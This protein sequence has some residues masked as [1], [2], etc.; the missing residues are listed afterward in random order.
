MLLPFDAAAQFIAD[1]VEEDLPLK[2]WEAGIRQEIGRE[3][4]RGR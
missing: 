3:C 1:G 2:L 4:K